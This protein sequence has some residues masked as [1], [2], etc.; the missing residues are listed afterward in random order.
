MSAVSEGVV[1][2]LLSH[3]KAVTIRRRWKIVRCW[4]YCLL[5]T[6][7]FWCSFPSNANPGHNIYL[8]S[9]ITYVFTLYL[10]DSLASSAKPMS[11]SSTTHKT[12]RSKCKTPFAV[13]YYPSTGKTGAICINGAYFVSSPT[14]FVGLKWSAVAVIVWTTPSAKC[15]DSCCYGH[16]PTF[17]LATA[18]FWK[19]TAII[20]VCP[21][22]TSDR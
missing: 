15:Y 13:T 6:M 1:L 19:V 18:C 5:K 8:T 4:K 3:C 14:Q 2:S 12:K 10:F 16:L 7:V 11:Q 21:S 22:V 20:H 17:R 9:Y